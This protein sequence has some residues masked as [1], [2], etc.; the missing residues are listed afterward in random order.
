MID[1]LYPDLNNL[2]A[3]SIGYKNKKIWKIFHLWVFRYKIFSVTLILWKSSI[4][5]VTVKSY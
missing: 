1:N 3:T 2:I 4:N 5:T